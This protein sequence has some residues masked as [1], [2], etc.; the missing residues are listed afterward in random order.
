MSKLCKKLAA[1]ISRLTAD[2]DAREREEA[3]KKEEERT[4][5]PTDPQQLFR[6]SGRTF[7]NP[8]SKRILIRLPDKVEYSTVGPIFN[9]VEKATRIDQWILVH[10]YDKQYYSVGLIGADGISTNKEVLDYLNE[11]KY[12][13][14]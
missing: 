4:Q 5:L 13:L 9:K 7:V 14:E 8:H 1:D 12:R 6:Y 11:Y 10:Y 2:L 3:R